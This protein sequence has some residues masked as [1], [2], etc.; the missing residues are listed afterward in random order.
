MSPSAELALTHPSA[1]KNETTPS[2][3][4]PSIVGRAG[5]VSFRGLK[6]I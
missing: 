6:L 5:H 3:A 4:S 1:V 2:L